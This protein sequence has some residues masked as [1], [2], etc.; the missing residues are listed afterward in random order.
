MRRK[1]IIAEQQKRYGDNPRII[2]DGGRRV[3][4]PYY[5]REPINAGDEMSPSGVKVELSEL[6]DDVI[7]A[8]GTGGGGSVGVA[9]Y[10]LQIIGPLDQV[11]VPYDDLGTEIVSHARTLVLFRGRR[12][13]P[14]IA[15]T[16]LLVLTCNAAPAGALSW[17][18]VDGAFALKSVV[19]SLVVSPGD[20]L[21]LTLVTAETGAFDVST[22]VH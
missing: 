4:P 12:A 2:V 17:T 8:I 9:P 11:P 3:I 14:G 22:E 16:T 21:G 7:A 1:A 20:R 19:I 15:G 10:Q 13:I 5:P 18:P 6:A